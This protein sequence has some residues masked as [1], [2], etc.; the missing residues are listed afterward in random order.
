MFLLFPQDGKEHWKAHCKEM[1]THT[2][3]IKCEVNSMARICRYRYIRTNYTGTCTS[4]H[5]KLRTLQFFCGLGQR[6]QSQHKWHANSNSNISESSGR[7]ACDFQRERHS[8]PPAAPRSLLEENPISDWPEAS[9]IPTPDHTNIR[10]VYK[11]APNLVHRQLPGWLCKLNAT[12][13]ARILR[14]S[15]GCSCAPATTPASW[16]RSPKT[17]TILRMV[18][19]RGRTGRKH[20]HD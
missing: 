8:Q 10:P 5:P 12:N 7:L 2:Y 6:I 20:H 18:F 1:K 4:L 16:P 14:Q 17:C 15:H 11:H 19:G 9:T 13:P 3:I